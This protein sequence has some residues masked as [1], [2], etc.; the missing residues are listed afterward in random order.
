VGCILLSLA[1]LKSPKYFCLE[2]LLN[3]VKVIK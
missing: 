3:R 1:S 2:L